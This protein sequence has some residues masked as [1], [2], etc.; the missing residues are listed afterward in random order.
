MGLSDDKHG[1]S[2]A[3]QRL[4]FEFVGDGEKVSDFF[5]HPLVGKNAH[6]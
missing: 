5:R 4:N 3:I 6:G 2:H 1:V